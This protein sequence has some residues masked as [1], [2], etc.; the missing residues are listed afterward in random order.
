[1]NF[2]AH[3]YRGNIQAIGKNIHIAMYYLNDKPDFKGA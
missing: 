2:H 1:M 3:G